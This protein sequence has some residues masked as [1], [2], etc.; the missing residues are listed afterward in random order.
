MESDEKRG[1]G[2]GEG[3]SSTPP[4][5]PKKPRLRDAARAAI[6]Q[7]PSRI[8]DQLLYWTIRTTIE[9]TKTL[10]FPIVVALTLLGMGFYFQREWNNLQKEA[11]KAQQEIQIQNNRSQV[12]AQDKISESLAAMAASQDESNELT[13]SLMVDLGLTLPQK[14]KVKGK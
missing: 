12:A 6:S 9:A 4:P 2:K 7:P 13:R 1:E 14:R 5:L 3:E 8:Q 11:I 10:G